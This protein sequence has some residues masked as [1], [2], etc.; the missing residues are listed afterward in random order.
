MGMAILTMWIKDIKKNVSLDG[1]K[2]RTFQ[3]ICRA[4]ILRMLRGLLYSMDAYTK[5]RENLYHSLL[6]IVVLFNKSKQ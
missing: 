6:M 4:N 2:G 1:H 3:V 5:D